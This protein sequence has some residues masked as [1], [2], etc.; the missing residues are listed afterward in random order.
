MPTVPVLEAYKPRWTVE[1][2][3][4]P[5]LRQELNS[6]APADEPAPPAE[7]WIAKWRREYGISY[8]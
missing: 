1:L 2:S 6:T 8:K 4:E 7:N 3:V 5:N